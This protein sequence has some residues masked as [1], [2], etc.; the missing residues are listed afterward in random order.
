M[1]AVSLILTIGLAAT[2]LC[3]HCSAAV[4]HWILATAIACAG[5]SPALILMAPAWPQ[6]FTFS[7]ELA[8]GDRPGSGASRSANVSFQ[9]GLPSTTT[10]PSL[11]QRTARSF[12][13]VARPL[14]LAGSAVSLTLLIVGLARLR[15]LAARSHRVTRGR[16]REIA[17]AVA[18]QHGLRRTVTLL[19]SEH[20]SLLVTWGIVRPRIILP[21][22]AN[23]WGDERIR[24]VIAH[25]LAH[26]VRGDWLT[27][28]MA[29]LLR[30]AYWFNPLAWMACSRLRLESEQ[31]CDDVVLN[32]GVESPA[33]ATHLLELARAVR[34]HRR[35]LAPGYPA[36]AMAR[37]CSLERRITAMLK[38]GRNRRP[39]GV[40]SRMVVSSGLLAVS[41]LIAGLVATAQSFST[42][43][44][45][46]LDQRGGLVPG[47]TIT[48][49]NSRNQAKHEVTS[50]ESGQFEF[51]GLPPG[52]YTIDAG[53]SGFRP[54][55]GSL[56]VAGSNIR[57]DLTLQIGAL[58]ETVTVIAAPGERGA[59]DRQ[60]QSV[61]ARRPSAPSAACQTS[62]NGGEIRPP[63]K[64]QNVNPTYPDN[65]DGSLQGVVILEGVVSVEGTVTDVKVLRNP[66]P[67]LARAATEAFE[68]WVFTPTLLNCVPIEVTI[69]ATMNFALER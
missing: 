41:V 34:N 12:A 3:R 68:Q 16:W 2:A 60:P 24:V 33:Y 20:P 50:T 37:P 31:A 66:H 29:E 27:Q 40:A 56:T 38:I 64:I 6:P 58:T 63:M 42:F 19:Q 44:G 1:I 21:A 5:I 49:T 8:P 57:R 59:A 51:V 35:R 62:G 4:R 54:L 10:E 46:V 13:S 18:R 11:A 32:A 28:M 65:P 43:S 25:E 9:I 17:D 7:L 36:P 39:A 52:E 48:L 53:L 23:E 14:W 45:S 61:D 67:E 15:W 30:V 69:T 47:A 55:R 26:I 22:T